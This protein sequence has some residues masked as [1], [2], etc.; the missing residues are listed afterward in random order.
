MHIGTLGKGAEG[1][2]H[3][4]CW[5]N[6]TAGEEHRRGWHPERFDRAANAGLPVLVVGAGP[7]G[8]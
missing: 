8:M 4:G 2:G 6:P 3:L 5:Q 1:M 7:A